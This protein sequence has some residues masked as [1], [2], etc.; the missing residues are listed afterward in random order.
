[1]AWKAGPKGK[2]GDRLDTAF[3]LPDDR[4]ARGCAVIQALGVAA[5]LLVW[6]ASVDAE[7]EFGGVSSESGA[8][9][10]GEVWFPQPVSLTMPATLPLEEGTEADR[11]ALLV[12]SR[13]GG[14]ERACAYLSSQERYELVSCDSDG[15]EVD[16]GDAVAA[17]YVAVWS[18]V[19][20]AVRPGGGRIVIDF[21]GGGRRPPVRRGD[22]RPGGRR[23]CVDRRRGPLHHQLMG[24]YLGSRS[25]G[26]PSIVAPLVMP[27]LA[28]HPFSISRAYF[29]G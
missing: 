18:D 23:A 1:M 16:A 21:T 6:S 13:G 26:M 9:C 19:E 8:V 25:S 10:E 17:D 2:T 24:R 29:A 28:N 27:F 3:R 14:E 20:Q 22:P 11:L 4:M 15:V 5:W 7:P 12:W